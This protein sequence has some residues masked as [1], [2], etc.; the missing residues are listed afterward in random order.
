MIDNINFMDDINDTDLL[1]KILIKTK[2]NNILK[3]F[4]TE[5]FTHGR[6]SERESRSSP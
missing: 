4:L 6:K 2:S 5:V 1:K 3:I